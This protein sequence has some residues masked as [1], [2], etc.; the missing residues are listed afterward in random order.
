MAE[1]R[2]WE[3]FLTEQDQKV[4]AA[5]GYGAPVGFGQRP[6]L[7]VIDVSYA[8]VGDKPEPIL[9]SI[10]KWMN[11]CGEVGWKAVGKIKRLLDVARPKGIPVIYTT[12]IY[13][14][15]SWD[16]GSWLFKNPRT[17][18]EFDGT[19]SSLPAGHRI[20]DAIAPQ[21]KDIVLGKKKPSA[22]FGTPLTS[23]LIQLQCDSLIVTGLTTSG[24]VRATVVDAFNYNYRISVVED[25]CADRSQA[26]HAVSLCDMHAKYADV[27]ASDAVVKHLQS[28]P[29]RL[30]DLPAG[31]ADP[32]RSAA[33][34]R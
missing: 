31:V 23:H 5:A 32:M 17:E 30:F 8:F 24:C 2:I 29:D 25:A 26:S 34:T 4:L 6:A 21:P 9:K 12:G 16:L 33:Q 7:L 19:D 22:F 13:R 18:K 3:S 28:L 10:E 20:V 14:E 1:K 11:S 27:V 15:D